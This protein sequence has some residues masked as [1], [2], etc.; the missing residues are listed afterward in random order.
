MSEEMAMS[1]GQNGMTRLWRTAGVKWR[2]LG[3]TLQYQKP[4]LYPWLLVFTSY[5]FQS[6][7]PA[8]TE[9]LCTSMSVN[10][11]A[12]KCTRHAS[13]R[14]PDFLSLAPNSFRFKLPCLRRPPNPIV[15]GILSTFNGI[16][17]QP[18]DTTYKARASW[19]TRAYTSSSRLTRR[20]V[21]HGFAFPWAITK[22]FCRLSLCRG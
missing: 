1:E 18:L 7:P 20:C 5:P 14:V 11:H 4:S 12:Y 21:F 6:S 3:V 13:P 15:T 9:L 8:Q 22:Q 16:W 10:T 19:R 17:V 2:Q